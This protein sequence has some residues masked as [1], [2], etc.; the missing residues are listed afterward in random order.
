M[1]DRSLD[2]PPTTE[3]GG[4]R[5]SVLV[6]SWNAAATI[7]RSLESL[8]AECDVPFE[9]IV[10][11]DASADG[12]LDVVHELAERD[13]RV[14]VLALPT[15]AGVSNARNRGL[16]VA[17][18]E[19]IAFLDADD[20]L[21]PGALAALMRPTADPDVRAVIGQRVHDDGERQWVARG[22][23]NPD[24]REP[25][26]KSI[27]ANP[28]LMN[29]AAIH[30][31]LFHRSLLTDLRFEGRVLG[32]QPWTI[33]ALLRAG[34]GIEVVADTVYEWSRPHPDHYVEGITSATR[35]SSARAAE[36]ARQAAVVFRAVSDEVD[37]R[38]ED[39]GT[40]RVVLRAYFDRLIRMDIGPAVRDALDRRD[41]GTPALYDAVGAFLATVPPTVLRGSAALAA[42][43]VVAPARRWPDLIPPA[44]PS[45]W[46]MVRPALR[47]GVPRRPR[48]TWQTLAW[49]A[50]LLARRSASPVS[51]R[52]ASAII[53]LLTAVTR[54]AGR[55]EHR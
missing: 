12:T 23:D 26:R 40:R 29:Y 35:S 39:E 45:Y 43:V 4:P 27:A 31:K 47:A 32:D 54:M 33:S 20:R 34:D 8:L 22:Y 37:A 16:D 51:S 38:L 10:I 41:P 14:V 48:G 52:M 19:W 5:V 30:G 36:M 9:C 11:D 28:G 2:A 53:D 7:H 55:L 49:P 3:S 13:D 21:F 18:G 17:R 42:T 25:G 44:K 15:N 24:I 1:S 50:F 6:P 46:T